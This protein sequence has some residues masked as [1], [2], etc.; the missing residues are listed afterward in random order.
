MLASH[1]QCLLHN[2]PNLSVT[3]RQNQI[4]DFSTASA[5]LQY[6]P[7]EPAK[8]ARAVLVL[9]ARYQVFSIPRPLD[10]DS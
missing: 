1:L 2:L 8:V 4:H 9:D 6:P 10:I 5:S 3:Q 7:T